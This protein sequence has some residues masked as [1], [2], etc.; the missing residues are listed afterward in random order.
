MLYLACLI[1]INLQE[2]W[3]DETSKIWFLNKVFFY[4]SSC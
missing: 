3:K 4:E 1:L 2:T